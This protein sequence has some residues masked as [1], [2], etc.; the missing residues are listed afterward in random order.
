MGPGAGP[1]DSWTLAVVRRRCVS[2][3]LV[4]LALISLAPA[5]EPEGTAPQAGSCSR[6]ARRVASTGREST[7]VR[8]A[9]RSRARRTSRSAR[10]GGTHTWR[11]MAATASP[12]SGASGAPRA[13]AGPPRLRP[14][15]GRRVLQGG[16][17][18]GR[19]R[20]D[21][22]E[23][24]RA[25]RLRGVG[26][27]RRAQHLQSKPADRGV[28]PAARRERVREPAAGRR[29]RGGP[30]PERADQRGREP[31]RCPRL[32]DGEALPEW[33]GGV[34][35]RCRRQRPRPP[36]A[37]RDHRGAAECGAARAL[38]SPRR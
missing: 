16:S 23:R 34:R 25:Q 12:S 5:Q 37:R 18:D 14:P 22:G 3:L 6:R 36:G 9:A 26:R 13:A 29:L 24:R 31:R 8:R 33:P 20:L 27:Q 11:L 17:S 30:G 7:A 15:R 1:C 32:R 35:P 19:P 28:D 4:L 2:A 38:A 10:T 21:S